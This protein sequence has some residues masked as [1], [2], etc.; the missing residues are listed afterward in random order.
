MISAVWKNEDTMIKGKVI[1]VIVTE[2]GKLDV[3]VRGVMLCISQGN[4]IFVSSIES[5]RENLWFW[6]EQLEIMAYNN[7]IKIHE[8]NEIK[9]N[10]CKWCQK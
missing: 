8:H 3:T 2:L 6:Q 7:H 5:R 1:S 4:F 9:R 10:K